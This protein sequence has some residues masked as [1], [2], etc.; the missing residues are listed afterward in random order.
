MT[1]LVHDPDEPRQLG[2]VGERVH[3]LGARR[4]SRDNTVVTI[5]NVTIASIVD[6]TE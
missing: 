2:V 3:S 6:R 4:T 5:M 1:V